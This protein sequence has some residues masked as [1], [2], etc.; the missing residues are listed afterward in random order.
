MTMSTST[1]QERDRRDAMRRLMR[2]DV[3]PEI[4]RVASHEGVAPAVDALV[5]SLAGAERRCQEL[6]GE[7]YRLTGLVAQLRGTVPRLTG[8]SRG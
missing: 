2:D 6:G 8:V 7:I 1:E 3:P 4:R 5:V